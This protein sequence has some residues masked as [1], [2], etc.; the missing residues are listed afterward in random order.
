VI[1]SLEGK[2]EEVS[3]VSCVVNCNGI[4]YGVNV[5]M[6]TLETLPTIGSPVKLF[7]Y[8]IYREDNQTL[9]GFLDRSERN[10]FKIVV[11]NVPGVGPKIALGMLSKFKFYDIKSAIISK[12]IAM[13]S[14]I[15]GIGKRTA[16]RMVVELSEKL[17]REPVDSDGS[18]MIESRA[19]VSEVDA[20]LALVSLGIRRS[21][22][23]KAIRSVSSRGSE[24]STEQLIRMALR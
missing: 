20:V 21:D 6:P 9:Y 23:E 13:L 4:G 18:F 19:S 11:E 10:F 15:T 7:I 1:V 5:P 22:A 17:S 8:S 16:E 3:G 14:S 2:L 12:N 24:L